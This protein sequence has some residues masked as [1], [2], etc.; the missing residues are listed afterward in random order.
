MDKQ[1]LGT[2]LLDNNLVT[3]VNAIF[4]HNNITKYS[5]LGNDSIACGDFDALE[6]KF[7][8]TRFIRSTVCQ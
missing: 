1:R 5:L 4:S 7:G 3:D 8:V 2:V 6:V